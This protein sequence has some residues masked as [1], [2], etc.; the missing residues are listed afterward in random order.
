VAAAA[1]AAARV[2]AA[3]VCA[4]P[5]G[6]SPWCFMRE[7][8]LVIDGHHESERAEAALV[9]QLL[10]RTGRPVCLLS[11][12]HGAERIQKAL[13]REHSMVWFAGHCTVYRNAGCGSLEWRDGRAFRRLF[14]DDQA[15]T[16]RT[17]LLVLSSCHTH[18]GPFNGKSVYRAEQMI[19]HCGVVYF[20]DS[21]VFAARFM[22]ELCLAPRRSWLQSETVAAAFRAAKRASADRGWRLERLP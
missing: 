3:V 17:R 19:G 21:L 16:A 12:H 13:L 15:R 2:V 1:A 20:K 18:G 6:Q 8:V 10:W 4:S 11:G 14:T 9:A 5:R 7:E 22:T